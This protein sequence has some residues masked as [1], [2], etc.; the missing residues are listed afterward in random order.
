VSTGNLVDNTPIVNA[1][2]VSNDVEERIVNESNGQKQESIRDAIIAETTEEHTI[3][4]R[5]KLR[6]KIAL[7][8][9]YEKQREYGLYL[10]AKQAIDKLGDESIKSI[11]KEMKQLV[12]LEAFHGVNI[13]DIPYPHRKKIIPSSMFL[14][15]KYRAD[16][17]FEKLKAR[18][19]AGGHRQDKTVTKAR[20]LRRQLIRVPYL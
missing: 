20:H 12:D 3:S 14:K 16:G 6:P 4:S 9:K 5:Y 7:K 17:T 2:I 11:S 8:G 18:L 10:T 1:D 19:V 13:Q 15:K